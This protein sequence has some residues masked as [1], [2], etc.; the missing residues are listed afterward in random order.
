MADGN[1][2]FLTPCRRSNQHMARAGSARA[3]ARRTRCGTARPD[4]YTVGRGRYSLEICAL[5]IRHVYLRVR[6]AI[7]RA[8]EPRPAPGR[9]RGAGA[10]I[11]K[12]VSAGSVSLG[13]LTP[14]LYNFVLP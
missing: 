9:R 14:V 3:R 7:L 1:K 10:T 5:K 13:V 2:R 11:I 12:R 6:A 8:R 4:R